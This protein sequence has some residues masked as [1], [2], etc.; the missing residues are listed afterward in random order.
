MPSKRNRLC[1]C[2]RIAIMEVWKKTI[3]SSPHKYVCGYHLRPFKGGEYVRRPVVYSDTHVASKAQGYGEKIGG[4]A[5]I[6]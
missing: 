3:T 5:P 6:T 4:Y 1:D 2:G